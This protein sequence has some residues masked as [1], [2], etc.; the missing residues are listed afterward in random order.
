MFVHLCR[1][2]VWLG[3][4][5]IPTRTLSKSVP[6]TQTNQYLE[7]GPT[8][9]D[10]DLGQTTV[11]YIDSQPVESIPPVALAGA[12]LY[13]KG[14]TGYGG[15]VA[16]KLFTYNYASHIEIAADPTPATIKK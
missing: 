9:I 4:P 16:P 2:Q 13:H 1:S 10:A 7:F 14:Q 15:F 8:D 3:K 6:T 12:G 5:D 11:P